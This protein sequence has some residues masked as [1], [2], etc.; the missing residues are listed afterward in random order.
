MKK[1]QVNNPNWLKDMPRKQLKD[2]ILNLS[3][4]ITNEKD[5]KNLKLFSSW[6]KEAQNELFRR[7]AIIKYYSNK[8]TTNK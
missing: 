4:I 1:S 2:Y 3:K 6:L 5:E 8:K 7:D